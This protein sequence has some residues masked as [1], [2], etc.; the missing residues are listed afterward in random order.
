ML[1]LTALIVVQPVFA[2]EPSREWD[3]DNPGLPVILPDDSEVVCEESTIRYLVET[4]KGE[5]GNKLN[6]DYLSYSGT[7][8]E[9]HVLVND[10]HD[11]E[12]IRLVFSEY[13][14]TAKELKIY[15][16]ET[17]EEKEC[18]T[19]TAHTF[20]EKK[21]LDEYYWYHGNEFDFEKSME[22]LEK[23]VNED[24][25]FEP[26][27]KVT[28]YSVRFSGI[29]E[30]AANPFAFF[31]V[32]AQES[33]DVRRIVIPNIGATT[34]RSDMLEIGFPAD[35]ENEFS[36]YVI[37][38]MLPDDAIWQIVKYKDYE[39]S[40]EGN[41]MLEQKSEMTFRD[42]ALKEY[43]KYQGGP[44]S[45]KDWYNAVVNYIQLPDF[46]NN[47]ISLNVDEGALDI[48]DFL[49]KWEVKSFSLNPDEKVVIELSSDVRPY[50]HIGY[51][52][53]VYEFKYSYPEGFSYSDDAEINV[54]VSTV[55]NIV[56]SNIEGFDTARSEFVLSPE[57]IP[58]DGI[59]FALSKSSEWPQEA[60]G[61]NTDW[62]MVSFFASIVS[63]PIL[64]V[65]T[66][67]VLVFVLKNK[68]RN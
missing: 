3:G 48:I 37:G 34:V 14:G 45:E 41:V 66:F 52:T 8:S 13:A 50:G 55:Y 54:M 18:V 46:G 25:F 10:N 43:G 59:E 57:D 31:S 42:F 4:Y 17:G 63:G 9:R 56:G 33:H 23:T 20:S 61:I 60:R 24:S 47:S 49:D 51:V 58:E 32:P 30:T 16:E 65:A 5:G 15:N 36:F 21:W 29:D 12:E 39:I 28:E 38:E 7:L 19:D 27:M 40:Y 35:N 26:E 6:D 64:L 67:V 44:V 1:F 68:N 22:M 53:P 2:C 11:I 62:G